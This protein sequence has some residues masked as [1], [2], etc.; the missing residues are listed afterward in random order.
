MEEGMKY[1]V[2]EENYT[3]P[4]P[5]QHV[6]MDE[7]IISTKPAQN[8]NGD[9]CSD[10]RCGKKNDWETFAHGEFDSLAYA[11]KA[12]FSLLKD[13]YREMESSGDWRH[14]NIVARFKPGRYEPMS[15]QEILD[16]THVA[17]DTIT[18][19]TTDEKLMELVEDCVFEA[20]TMGAEL[21][22][23]TVKELFFKRRREQNE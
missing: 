4:H 6:D 3:G 16:W 19:K 11:R 12:V 23:E 15:I 10:G 21:D 9:V 1:Y 20:H 17:L 22:R 2:I 14:D 5:E 13:D 7:V 18:C 8:L